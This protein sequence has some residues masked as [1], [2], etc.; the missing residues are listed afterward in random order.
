ME[1][2]TEEQVDR[3]IDE[4]EELVRLVP[5][6]YDREARL[7]A[8]VRALREDY[9]K[10]LTSWAELKAHRDQLLNVISEKNV[11]IARVS[12]LPAKWRSE[13]EPY[14]RT[15]QELCADDLEAAL[16]GGE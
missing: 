7:A 5:G 2:P 12:A 1:R 13:F 11:A 15:A 4:A 3:D 8:E 16:T 10:L 14:D 9:D 6:P